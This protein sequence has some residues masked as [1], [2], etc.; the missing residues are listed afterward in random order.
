MF[1]RTLAAVAL[2][3]I[4]HVALAQ[5]PAP[6]PAAAPPKCE[7]PDPHPGRL[8]SDMKRKQWTKEVNDWQACMKTYIDG[9]GAKA[10]AAVKTANAAVAESNAAIAAYNESVK[11]YQA[12]AEAAR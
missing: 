3:A 12:Q 2:A 8:A 11:E 4:T 9:L 5:S 10:D 1:A 7:K 6:A